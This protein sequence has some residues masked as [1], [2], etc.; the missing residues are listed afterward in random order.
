MIIGGI[1]RFPGKKILIV[2]DDDALLQMLELAFEVEGAE[3]VVADNGRKGLQQFHK[4]QPDIVLL[5]V[6]MPEMNGWET[7]KQ[8]RLEANIPVIMMT[9]LA[10]DQNIVRGLENG[11]D[12]YVAKPFSVAVLKARVSAVLRRAALDLADEDLTSYVDE[13]LKINL[14]ERS[15]Y[16]AQERLKLSAT[17][18]KLLSF[19]LKHANQMLS[20]QQILLNIWGVE[21]RGNIDY[22]HVYVS[23]L[24]RKIEPDPRNPIYFVT[25]YGIGYRFINQPEAKQ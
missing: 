24:R 5:D 23:H 14:H 13:H 20:Y 6:L 1:V 7:C 22:V 3:V 15:V 21:Y 12:D 10:D 11:A 4:H 17:E 9:T 18:F 25:E 8:I 2:D 16:V 19:F